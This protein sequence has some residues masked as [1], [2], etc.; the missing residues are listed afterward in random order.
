MVKLHG[1]VIAPCGRLRSATRY[2]RVRPEISLG[3]RCLFPP[4]AKVPWF[5]HVASVPNSRELVV[6]R[7]GAQG[8]RRDLRGRSALR[9]RTRSGALGRFDRAAAKGGNTGEARTSNE[10][11]GRDCSRAFTQRVDSASSPRLGARNLR[12]EGVMDLVLPGE[13]RSEK[14]EPGDAIFI[15]R[16]EPHGFVTGPGQSCRFLVV[17]PCE[18][19][20]VR[21][22]S[23]LMTLM[24]TRSGKAE[25]K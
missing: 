11:E 5:L 21:N 23:F 22:S 12:P 20:P 7:I 19:P 15:P 17:A 16:D 6:L 2:A 3:V 24:S 4:V 8:Q 10:C 1:G 14:V 18:R 25:G 9:L 13:G